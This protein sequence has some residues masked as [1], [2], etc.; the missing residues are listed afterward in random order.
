MPSYAALYAQSINDP[1]GFWLQAAQALSW[2]QIPTKACD[3]SEAP[4]AKWFPDGKLNTCYNAVDRHVVAG[5]GDAPALIYDSPV[6]GSKRTYSFA[7]I[8]IEVAKIAGGLRALGVTQ[9]ET[10]LIYMPMVPEAIFAMLAC[11]RIGAVHSVVFG[12]FAP[13]EI[14]VRL[15]DTAAK[16]VLTATGS[17]E[18]N[19]QVPYIPL[20]TEALERA[21]HAPEAVVCLKRPQVPG[22]LPDTFQDWQEWLSDVTPADCVSLAASDPLYILYTS[23]T[24]GA[25]KGI[26]RDNG[27]HSVAL[28]W[29]M[30]HLYDVQAGQTFWAA[31]DIGWV[32]GHSYIV[33][34]P[35]LAGCATVLYEGKPVGTPDPGAFWRVIE[36][37]RVRALFTAPTAMRAIKQQDSQGAYLKGRDI[38]SLKY[39]YLAGERCDPPTAAWAE[40]M[41]GVPII[42]NW[43]QT[44]TGWAI[45]SN[46]MGLDAPMPMKP[47]S[48]SKPAPGYDVQVL[49]DE[50]RPGAA[51]E[52]GNLVVKLPLP[53]S[54]FGT[55]W[56]AHDRWT[57]TYMTQFPGYYQTGDAGFIDADGYVFVM[58]RTDDVMN[59]A[60]HRL[61]TGALEEVLASHPAVAECAVVGVA[62]ALKGQLPLGLLVLKAGQESNR[63]VVAECLALVREKIGPVAAFKLAVVVKRLPK[64]R[65]GKILRATLRKIADGETVSVPPT[66]DDPAILDEI[67][68]DLQSLGYAT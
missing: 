44:E 3:F 43:W 9:G 21:R 64:T 65:S 25:P 11:A 14:A 46:F 55:L 68:S 26:V 33:Y 1:E 15:D 57:Q 20:V 37:H 60:G 31:S 58:S 42:D 8:Q 56:R 40:A 13:R 17:L 29:S 5:R 28:L 18:P 36:E 24:T 50:G 48:P 62:D 34:A 7:E 51:G 47:G 41:L 66:I 67:K 38:S 49:C 12:G 63:D 30:K 16:V 39:L 61:S 2:D 23:G 27:G 4:A 19:R 54:C 45:C 52:I 6:T 53:P 10:V 59:V 35:L 22:D 32:V